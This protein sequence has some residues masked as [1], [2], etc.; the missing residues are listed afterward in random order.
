MDGTRNSGLI[1]KTIRIVGELHG[2]EDLVIEGRVEGTIKLKKH[3]TVEKTG[4]I[5][6][7]VE[8]EDITIKGEVKGNTNASNRVAVTRE[9]KVV[10]DIKAPR[11]VIEDG[12]V[13][14]G[15][16]VMDVKLPPDLQ[17]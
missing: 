6:A 10:G 5:D 15:S 13:L 2:E 1:Q 16:I 11:I 9:A 17:S 4:V 7:D 14:K 12:A 8:V 3:L